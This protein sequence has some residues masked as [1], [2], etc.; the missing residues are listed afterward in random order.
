MIELPMNMAFTMR[1]HFLQG[2]KKQNQSENN[3]K[4]ASSQNPNSFKDFQQ[5]VRL[6]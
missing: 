6:Q 1:S 3:L 4:K 5:G 2:S